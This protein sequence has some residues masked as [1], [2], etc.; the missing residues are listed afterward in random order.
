MTRVTVTSY[1]ERCY[2]EAEGHA[3]AEAQDAFGDTDGAEAAVCA[4]MSILMLTAAS[5]LSEMDARGDFYSACITV[6]PGY[7]LFDIHPRDDACEQ[8]Q[9]LFETLECGCALLEENYPQ[10]V[11]IC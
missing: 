6:Q 7:A 4:A 3:V 8:V 10:L 5:R 2:F 11:A 1:D 9:E